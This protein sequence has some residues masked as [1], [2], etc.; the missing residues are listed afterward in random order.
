MTRYSRYIGLRKSR[1]RRLTIFLIFVA[2]I[3]AIVIA[4]TIIVRRLYHEDLQAVNSSQKSQ[5]VTIAPGSSVNKIADTLQKDGL[6]R[7]ARAFEWYVRT[8]EV[9]DQLEAGTYAFTPSQDV[10]SI[11][12][13][14]TQGKVATKLVT[15]LPGKRLDQ[16]RVTLIND[17]F[18]PSSVDA[19][20]Q[21]AG[22][23][24]LPALADKPA[25]ANLE[26]LLYPDSFEKSASTDPSVIIRESL[27]EMGERLTPDLQTAFAAEGLTT[28]QGIILA[29]MIQQEVFKPADQTQVAQ[30]F[31]S[32][33]KIGMPLGS[34]VT[35]FY[36]AILA[37]QAPNTTYDSPYNTLLHTGLPPTPISTI[38]ANALN[39]AAHPA[40]TNWLYFVTGDDG[41]TYFSQTLDEQQQ[42][43]A[44]YCHKL[45][46][47]DSQ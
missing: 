13:T 1:R 11:V 44:Q 33:L 22:Y 16:I 25:G 35:A 30:V 29:S 4:A 12:A 46:S 37:G 31:L 10:P 2:A 39:A 21:S 45:C 41:T 8:Q 32:R 47:A 15:I 17:G 43:A 36:G 38:S 23:A 26:G 18:T 9:R 5:I 27:T 19:A 42:N 40:T 7:S 20:L 3:L 24:D 34:D 6:I 14:L 28:Y